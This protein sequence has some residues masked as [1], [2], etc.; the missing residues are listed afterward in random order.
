MIKKILAIGLSLL[1]IIPMVSCSKKDEKVDKYA[2]KMDTIMHLTAY[3]PNASK[4]IDEAFKRV[5]EIEKIASS[6]IE[7]SD[8]NKINEAAGKEYVKVHP[9]IVKI[10]KTSIEYSKI[11]NGAFDITVS[12]L[13]KL[14][15]IGTDEERVPA[16][17][18]IKDKLALVGYKNIS[19]NESDNS[20]KLMKAGMAIDLGGVAKGFTADEIVKVFKKYGVN[21]AIINLGGSSIYTLGVKPD[22]TLWSVAIQNPRKEKNEGNIGIVKLNQGALSTSGDYQRFFIKDGKR[23]HHI[24]DPFTGYPADAGVMSDT[25]RIDSNIPDCNMLADILTKVTFVSGVDKGMK[26]IDSIEGI[27]CMAVTTDFK[28]YKSS[29]WDTKIEELSPDFKLAN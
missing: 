4:A 7:T 9:E 2:T 16:D 23:Y 11:S 29:K 17:S 12:P 5:D 21:S 15:G 18:E 10:I 22:K 8:V 20:V 13:I 1:L 14:W 3:G 26:I 27:S 25:I 24:L 28:I 6:S 19:I